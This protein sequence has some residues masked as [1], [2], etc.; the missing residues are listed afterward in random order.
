MRANLRPALGEGVAHGV[1]VDYDKTD[2]LADLRSSE[3]YAFGFI[4]RIKHLGHQVFDA[5][6]IFGYGLVFGSEHRMAVEIYW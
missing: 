6:G 4:H 2:V 5:F 1:G 3:A